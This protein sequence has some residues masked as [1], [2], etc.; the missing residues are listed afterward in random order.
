[1]KRLKLMTDYDCWPLWDPDGPDNV[2][3]SS[4][5]LSEKLI[6]ELNAWAETFDSIL[7]RDTGEASFN[8]A[9]DERTFNETGKQLYAA[10][11]QEL[12]DVEIFYFDQEKNTVV[13]SRGN[14]E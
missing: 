8:S 10:L 5:N 7:N 13:N 4:L 14:Y 3:P 1:M 9:E 6:A 11:Q 12:P 2:D